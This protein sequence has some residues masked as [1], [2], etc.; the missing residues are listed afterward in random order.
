MLVLVGGDPQVDI[1]VGLHLQKIRNLD[2]MR[3]KMQRKDR[4][5][6]ETRRQR[7]LAAWAGEL[8][9][10]NKSIQQSAAG[11]MALKNKDSDDE[12]EGGDS[13]S[14]LDLRI[15]R[16]V[17]M[18]P[19]A[20]DGGALEALLDGPN[21]PP[22]D[23]DGEGPHVSLAWITETRVAQVVAVFASTLG[24]CV[25]TPAAALAPPPPPAPPP[26]PCT[27]ARAFHRLPGSEVHL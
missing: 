5:K 2:T 25:K 22:P 17:Q 3:N 19:S 23:E 15:L 26:T 8:N 9:E 7:V 18:R 14:D 24:G 12:E 4:A 10:F 21:G 11:E 16:D 1:A 13:D 27:C 6:K 20:I